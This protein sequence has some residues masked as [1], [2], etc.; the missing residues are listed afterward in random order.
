M[1]QKRMFNQLVVG[2]DDFLEMPDSSQNLYFHLSMRADDD[3][4]VDNWKSIMRMTGKKEDDLKILIAKSFIIPFESGIIVIKHWKLNNYIQKDRYKETIHIAEKS[5]LSTDK[6]NVYNLDT[7]CIQ[8]VYSDKISIDKISIDK[9]SIK[10]E[11]NK[12]KKNEMEF[13]QLIDEKI[14]N[15]ELKNTI[16]EFIKMRKSI[17]KTLTIRGLELI[18]DKL[19]KLSQNKEE[20]IMILNKSIMNNWQGIFSLNEEDKKQLKANIKY[21]ENT[22]TEEEYFKNGGGKRYV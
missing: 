12:K 4:F 18:I 13:D 22:M 10:K 1:A 17:K 19:N 20:Q 11:K 14:T 15:E 21:K 6:N 5:L 16:Y 7:A 9:N 2:S 8:N 3:G